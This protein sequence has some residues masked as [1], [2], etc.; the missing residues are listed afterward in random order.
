M[1]VL[2]L[3][4]VFW[5]NLLAGGSV[6][7][8]AG[9]INALDKVSE[10]E[11]ISNDKLEGVKRDIKVIRPHLINWLP[12]ACNEICYSFQLI[13]LLKV[14]NYDF[15]Y[16][17]YSG[18]SFAGAYLAKKYKVPFVLEFNS[19][20][21]WKT[22]HWDNKPKSKF[23]L[24]VKF[25]YEHLFKIPVTAILENYNIKA[26]NLIVVVS[27]PLKDFLVKKGID[28]KKILVNPNAVDSEVYYPSNGSFEIKQRYNLV[29]NITV[30]FIGTFGQW[31]GVI[32]MAKAILLFQKENPDL[33]S[34][35]KFLLI[36]DGVLLPEMKKILE[37]SIFQ[38]NIIFT[39]IIPQIE[40]PRY[41]DAC[42]IFLSPN[43]PNTDGT[44]FF[45]SPTKLFEYMAMGKGI[46]TSKLEQMEEIFEHKKTA[47]LVE[48]GNIAELAEAI[49]VLVKDPNLRED[50]GENARELV[51]KEYSWEQN[52]K[53]TINKLN[54]IIDIK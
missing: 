38:E 37:E 29:G 18:N 44:R 54:Q 23:K 10:L 50:I 48:P 49:K 46:I 26:A 12:M 24:L 1:R 6:G 52:V 16:Q 7:H 40:S 30:G 43:I 51:L 14:C 33:V 17:R 25:F 42:D 20:D 15:I 32:E 13:K 41:L 35:V 5:F 11:I 39:G 9:V 27:Q 8:T 28:D 45:N 3:R 19:S 21:L 31:H 22:K 53:K 4:T 34:N 47:Y 2:Y 36:G